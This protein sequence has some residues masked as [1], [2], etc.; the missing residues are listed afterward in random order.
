LGASELACANIA[1]LKVNSIESPMIVLKLADNTGTL[2][3]SSRLIAFT[4]VWT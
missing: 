1:E 2:C 3:L 4:T